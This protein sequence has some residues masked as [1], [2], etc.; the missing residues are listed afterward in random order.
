MI[1]EI[2][3]IKSDKSDL[4][5]FG[6]TV[7]MVFLIIAG[8][9]FLKEKQSFQLLLTIGIILFVTG[10]IIPVF[11]KPVYWTWMVFSTLLGWVM[12]RVILT[13][14]FYVILVPTGLI[15]RLF[16]TQFL[17]LNQNYSQTSY[18][19]KKTVESNNIINCEKQF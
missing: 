5:K 8:F 3:N 7:G 11:L 4:R 17:D 6:I 16:R 12:T 13:L 19:N 2:I 10:I 15:A 14:L 9:F 1:E 18:W